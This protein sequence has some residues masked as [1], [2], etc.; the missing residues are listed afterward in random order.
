V[1]V[2]LIRYCVTCG[3]EVGLVAPCLCQTCGHEYWRNPKPC[4]GACVVNDETLLLVLRAKD[5]GAG[6]WDLPAGSAI[7][8]SIHW[9]QLT[10]RCKKKRDSPS[11]Q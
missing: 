9:Q 3:R 7:P 6:L 10:E 2:S 4:G 8:K 11:I 1:T 5:P